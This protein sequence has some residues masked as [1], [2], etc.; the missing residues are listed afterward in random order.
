MTLEELERD[1][2]FIVDSHSAVTSVV[3]AP[4]LWQKI[5]VALEEAENREMVDL[6][7]ERASFGPMA[8]ATLGLHDRLEAWA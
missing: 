5:L 4:E 8:I 6:L 3:L 2:Q 1:V 7:T